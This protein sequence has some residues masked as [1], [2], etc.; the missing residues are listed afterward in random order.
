[1]IQKATVDGVASTHHANLEGV[2]RPRMRAEST[3]RALLGPAENLP[4]DLATGPQ[5]RGYLPDPMFGTD[6]Y[7]RLPLPMPQ[8]IWGCDEFEETIADARRSPDFTACCRAGRDIWDSNL[9]IFLA[10][11]HHRRESRSL[12][13][14]SQ[15]RRERC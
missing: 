14:R 10:T 5:R 4:I 1:M 8:E 12:L 9:E 6:R 13:R 11:A 7:L 15:E 2:F 3:A